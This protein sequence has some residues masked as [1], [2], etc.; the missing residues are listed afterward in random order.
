VYSGV[1]RGDVPPHWT[2][3]IYLFQGIFQAPTGAEPPWKEN[4][5]PTPW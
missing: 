4:L 2:S 5:S 1:F 3:E